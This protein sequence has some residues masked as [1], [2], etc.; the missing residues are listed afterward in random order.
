MV[1]AEQHGTL[2]APQSLSPKHPTHTP[3]PPA[4]AQEWG[5][6]LRRF[7]R[8]EDD[9]VELLLTLEEYCAAEGAFEGPGE[10]GAPFAAIFAQVRVCP[11]C[12]PPPARSRPPA[13]CRA[14]PTW[15][16]WGVCA[17]CCLLQLPIPHPPTTTT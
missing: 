15:V 11:A 9:Q 16:E 5:P 14:A 7:L 13:G 1:G 8:S 6:L 12:P 3:P 2:A 17:A 4:R 10:G